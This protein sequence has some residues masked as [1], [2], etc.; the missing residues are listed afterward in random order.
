MHDVIII[1]AGPAG[2]A[3]AFWCDDLGLDTLVL[4]REPRVGGQLLQ[5]YN[6]IENYPGLKLANGQELSGLLSAEIDAADFDLWT[7]VEISALNLKAKQIALSSGE[8]LQAISIIVATGVRRRMLGIPGEAEFAGK[9]IIE[10]ATRDRELFA[11]HDVCVIGG[12]DAAAENAL[13]LAEVC[14]TVTVIHRRKKLRARREFVQRIESNHCLTVFS[15]SVVTRILGDKSVEA[16]EIVRKEAIKPFQMAV[17]GVLIR[18]GVEPNTEQ[19]RDQLQ[20]DEK[21]YVVVDSKHETSITNVFAI[22][23]VSNPLAPTISGACGAGATAAK[24]IASRLT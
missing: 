5:V 10:S 15:E 8:E 20:L 12:G 21:G 13:L 24:V 6:P 3:A 2:L 22:G 18:I 14:P 7:G 9:G 11:G 19:L 23:D 16:V 4:E 17:R 1:G